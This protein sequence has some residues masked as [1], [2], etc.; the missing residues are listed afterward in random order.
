MKM[1][2]GAKKLNGA[3]VVLA[4]YA[5]ITDP[6]MSVIDEVTQEEKGAGLAELLDG[7]IDGIAEVIKR[8]LMIDAAA[9]TVLA[10]ME[11]ERGENA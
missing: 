4:S 5:E 10:K 7:D 1:Q 3:A 9:C 8:S 2:V 6:I 11:D